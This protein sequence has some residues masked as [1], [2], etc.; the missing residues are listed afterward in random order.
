ML[1]N[2]RAPL[3]ERVRDYIEFLL[4]VLIGLLCAAPFFAEVR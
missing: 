1:N 2:H 4:V 3:R